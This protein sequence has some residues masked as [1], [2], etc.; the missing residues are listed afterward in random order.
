MRNVLAL[1]SFMIATAL[2]AP[3]CVAEQA[4]SLNAV[5]SPVAQ[6]TSDEEMRLLE[7]KRQEEE[8]KRKQRI[9]KR[10]AKIKKLEAEMAQTDSLIM[11]LSDKMSAIEK[12]IDQLYEQE[13]AARLKLQGK[14]ALFNATAM[15]IARLERMP[16]E[17]MAAATNLR[18]GYDRKSVVESGRKSLSSI[19][20]Q[21]RDD[22]YKIQEI[23]MQ[24]QDKM[25]EIEGLRHKMLAE[26]KSVQNLF[27]KQVELLSKD[28]S[29]K[30]DL[31]L[32]AQQT[33]QSKTVTDL[34]ERYEGRDD[35][36]PPVRHVLKKLPVKGQVVE[37]YNQRKPSGLFSK[38]IR[39]ETVAK[40]P[41]VGLKDGR[42]IYSDTF[43]DYG[44]MVIVEHSDG[45]HTLYS[46]MEK[47]SITVGDFAPAGQV[48]GF[49][50]PNKRPELYLEVRKSGKT[51]D[52]VKYLALN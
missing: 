17:A 47:S 1:L 2:M 41:V 30:A 36:L 39:I 46:G 34:L 6:G 22:I 18:S 48:L 28:S 43:R 9:A 21:N 15:Q 4:K 10:V 27:D 38:G 44:F 8:R 50:S 7:L 19:I 20:Y 24:R 13:D 37:A 40:E 29:L 33:K 12:D 11:S 25:D 42:V 26:R 3:V 31:M 23:R 16:L 51:I 52:P 35:Y 5:V 32:K 49:M 14:L 45:S